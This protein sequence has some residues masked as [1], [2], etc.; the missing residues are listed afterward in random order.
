MEI[1]RADGAGA[2]RLLHRHAQPRAKVAR[3]LRFLQKV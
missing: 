2:K 3:L 1:R